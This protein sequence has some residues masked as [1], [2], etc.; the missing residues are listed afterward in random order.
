MVFSA[1]YRCHC[2]HHRVCVIW[3]PHTSGNAAVNMAN[4]RPVIKW[5]I[6]RYFWSTLI[7]GL[8]FTPK[9]TFSFS[10]LWNKTD[11][12]EEN[13]LKERRKDNKPFTFPYFLLFKSFKIHLKCRQGCLKD[14]QWC[15]QHHSAVQR[16]EWTIFLIRK[17]TKSIY[18]CI[19]CI[20]KVRLMK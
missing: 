16:R 3:Y 20:G 10:L 18:V 8:G 6:R 15:S 17:G 9:R 12:T 13:I 1:Q 7:N 19:L 4:K 5:P 2:V 11:E 14:C